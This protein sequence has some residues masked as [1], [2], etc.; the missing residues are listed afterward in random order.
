M[1]RRMVC[2]FPAVSRAFVRSRL[3]VGAGTQ[4]ARARGMQPKSMDER[5]KTAVRWLIITILTV[6]LYVAARY[7]QG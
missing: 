6:V 2:A 7:A 5:S 1:Y 3:N 4:I